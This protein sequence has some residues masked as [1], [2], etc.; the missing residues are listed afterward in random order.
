MVLTKGELVAS[1]RHEVRVLLH[2][3]SKVDPAKLDYRS[4]AKQRSLLELLQYM[5]IVGPIH[6]RAV[7]GGAFDMDAWRNAW[8]TGEAAA[9]AMNLEQAKDAI[10]KQPALFGELLGPCSDA[11]LRAEIEM[12]GQKASRGSWLVRLVLCH[13]VAYRM[14]LFL[15]LKACGREELNTMNLWVGMDGAM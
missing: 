2:L 10:G 13:Y 7:M 6:F 14:Q 4:T 3:A 1:L 11:D 8:Q 15:Y 12:F 9:K 5:T